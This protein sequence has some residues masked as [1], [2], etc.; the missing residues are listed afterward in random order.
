LKPRFKYYFLLLLI[1]SVF[2]SSAQK[3]KNEKSEF[4]INQYKP[5]PKDR[6]VFELNHTGWLNMP[7]G[8][9]ETLTSGGVN[10]YLFFDHPIGNS[11]FSFA[12]G[13]G[14]SSHNIHGKQ[15]L[16]TH[17]DTLTGRETMTTIEK[18]DEP[19]RIN[20]IGFKII[21]VP[22]EF[23]FRTRTSYQFKMMVGA[24]FGY[25][26]HTFTKVYDKNQKAKYFDIYG[27]NPFR[28]GITMRVG[29]EQVYITAFYALSEVFE[30]GKGTRGVIPFSIGL[31]WTPRIS[32]GSGNYIGNKDSA[33]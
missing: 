29:V 12:W 24:K 28:Y 23:R 25:V 18:R 9:R 20:R 27:V 2:Y 11:R 5:S 19:Y 26:A 1:F 30:K 33:E 22:I 17:W 32:L 7:Y 13:G 4:D 6:V 15:K 14:L 31:A 10:I 3:K 8:L 21:E 16:V